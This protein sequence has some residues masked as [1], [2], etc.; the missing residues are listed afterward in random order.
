MQTANERLETLLALALVRAEAALQIHATS[1]SETVNE[2]FQTQLTA[3]LFEVNAPLNCLANAAEISD[4]QKRLSW[5]ANLAPTERARWLQFALRRTRTASRPALLDEHIHA[6]HVVEALRSES[7]RT[8]AI[9]LANLPT[10][11]ASF[12]ARQ[13]D[14]CLSRTERRINIIRRQRAHIKRRSERR[15]SNADRRRTISFDRRRT[16]HAADALSETLTTILRKAFLSHFARFESITNPTEFDNFTGA[17]LARF[18][19]LLGVREIAHACRGI[20]RIE[21]VAAFL[22]RFPAEDAKAIT[23][24]LASLSSLQS[25]RV[26]FAEDA[27][28]RAMTTEE[29]ARSLIDRAG[30]MILGTAMR[31]IEPTRYQYTRQKFP[32]DAARA[33]DASAFDEGAD[34]DAAM[35]KIIRDEV[36]AVAAGFARALASARLNVDSAREATQANA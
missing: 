2:T 29:D 14:F 33:L 26:R 4:L 28:G 34:D 13:L 22:K 7:R 5:Y 25:A 24:Y 16:P 36:T 1:E 6:S 12:C 10:R 9:I 30:L 19:H 32:L 8:Q 11:L 15:I 18:V 35:T 17:Q 3:Q 27:M 20:G 31:G 23:V 21:S